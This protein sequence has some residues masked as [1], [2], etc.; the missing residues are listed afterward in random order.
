VTAN[1]QSKKQVMKK[2]L[3]TTIVVL[4]VCVLSFSNVSAQ[5]STGTSYQTA[6]G[7]GIDL[8]NGGTY[9]G[10]SVKHFFTKS[11]AG[12]A[13]VLF[14]DNS[15]LLS[16]YYQY[17]GDIQNAAGLKWTLGLGG[18]AIF[19]KYYE[20]DIAIRPT[21]GLDFKIPNVPLAFDFDWRPAFT[22]THGSDF[23]AVRFGFGFRYTF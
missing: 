13:E 4:V 7:L 16:V 23:E 19:Y 3:L 22:I 6:V 5:K 1:T 11:N 15:T 9:V 12:K 14:G 10:P 18:S 21:A 20:D 8:G 17:H 2:N